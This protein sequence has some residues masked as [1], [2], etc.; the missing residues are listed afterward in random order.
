MKPVTHILFSEVFCMVFATFANVALRPA[1]IIMIALSAN[2]P[3]IDDTKSMMGKIFY[4]VSNYI[5]RRFGRRAITHSLPGLGIVA[6]MISPLLFFKAGVLYSMVLLSIL[7]HIII[8]CA[9]K[10][11][12]NLFYP[13]LVRA[14][15]PKDEKSRVEENSKTENVLSCV[16]IGL[17]LVLFPLNQ[18]G[19]KPALHYLIRTPEAAVTDYMTFS[20]QSYRVLVDFEGVNNISQEKIR[21]VWEAVDLAAKNSLIIKNKEGKL[22]RI[23]NDINDNIRPIKI[24]AVRGK[25]Q[26]QL[27]QK[28]ILK[29]NLLSDILP[30]ISKDGESYVSGYIRTDGSVSVRKEDIDS[31]QAIKQVSGK[32]ELSSATINDLKEKGL[33][34][35]FAQ[36]G[37]IIVRTIYPARKRMHELPEREML[38]DQTRSLIVIIKGIK[39]YDDIMVKEA[40]VV[41]KGDVLAVLRDK[42]DLKLIELKKAEISLG[43]AKAELKAQKRKIDDEL[44]EKECEDAILGIRRELKALKESNKQKIQKA[45]F[46]VYSGHLTVT[47]LK[48]SLK[49]FETVSPCNGKVASVTID[50]TSAKI[51]I[52][53]DGK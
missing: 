50:G 26:G 21:G 53:E 37:Q 49:A 34:D 11:G 23:G 2:L 9:N 18:I 13:N 30:L 33:L 39:G 45:Y 29:N 32:I 38:L 20:G 15:I 47:K 16:F 1:G 3:D 46:H 6:A 22:Y 14:V 48:E 41:K 36:D 19:I 27:T 40:D 42:R 7:G 12:V 24:R 28:I 17:I 51:R 25:R 10:E 44:K 4:P 52:T 43:A 8:D 5:E 35:T 31:Y